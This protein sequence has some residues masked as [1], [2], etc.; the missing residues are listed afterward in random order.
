MNK[1]IY[2]EKARE[3]MVDPRLILAWILGA[4]F[5]LAAL[6]IV[7][8]AQITIGVTPQNYALALFLA[9]MLILGTGLL[10]IAV[11]VSTRHEF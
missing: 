5:M 8:N 11:A 6:W 1:R 3:M 10:W 2:R 9:F 7:S 4:A